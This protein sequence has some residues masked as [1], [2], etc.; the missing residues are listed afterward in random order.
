M[1]LMS[2]RTLKVRSRR[3]TSSSLFPLQV[4]FATGEGYVEK[5]VKVTW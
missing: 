3:A 4:D 1:T 5:T 2:D